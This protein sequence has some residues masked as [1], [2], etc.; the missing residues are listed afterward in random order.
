M[1]KSI[2]KLT[3][4]AIDNTKTV[5]GGNDTKFWEV[6]CDEHGIDSKGA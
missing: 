1:K 5:K 4:K 3:T 2:K 6:I